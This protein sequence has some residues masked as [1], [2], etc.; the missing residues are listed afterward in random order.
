MA[1]QEQQLH[2]TE[3]QWQQPAGT[4]A[5]AAHAADGASRAAGCS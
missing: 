3:Q 4:A 2:P 5:A 1:E